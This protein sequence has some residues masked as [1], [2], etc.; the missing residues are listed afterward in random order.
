MNEDD[1]A[2]RIFPPDRES[3]KRILA[4]TAIDCYSRLLRLGIETKGGR[5]LEEIWRCA[6]VCRAIMKESK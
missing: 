3:F 4:E 6:Q 1:V 2:P 5:C